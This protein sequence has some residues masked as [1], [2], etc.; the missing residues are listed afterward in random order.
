MTVPRSEWPVVVGGCHRSGKSL[1]RCLPDAHPRIHYGPEV[2]F[3]RDFYG[4]YLEDALH[5]LRFTQA[6]RSLLS[7]DELLDVLGRGFVAVHERAA[8]RAGKPRWADKAP[9][10]VLPKVRLTQGVHAS[11]VGRWQANLAESDAA[12]IWG[13]T[14]DLW[15]QIDPELRWSYRQRQGCR[16]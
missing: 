4:D 7:E 6:A 10:N 8:N 16:P 1:V 11:S 5:H 12:L 13:G 9:E 14:C 15:E 2:P 3:F